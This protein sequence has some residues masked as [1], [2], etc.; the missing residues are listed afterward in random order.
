MTTPDNSETALQL[1]IR[2]VK[3][4]EGLRL[5]AY[6][7]ATGKPLEPSE[8]PKGTSTI[9]WGHVIS[10]AGEVEGNAI[11]EAEAARLLLQDIHRAREAVAY[12][13]PPVLLSHQEAALISFAFNLGGGSLGKKTGIGRALRERR[14]VDVPTEI[15][16][17]NKANGKVSPGLVRRRDAEARLW[18]GEPLDAIL[19]EP[20][21]APPEPRTRAAGGE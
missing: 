6:D 14:F 8:R 2:L 19:S 21:P 12:H 9:G 20:A 11:T 16:R 4:F 15:R 1:A 18:S 17:W 13:A 7:D 3:H 5:E 10:P